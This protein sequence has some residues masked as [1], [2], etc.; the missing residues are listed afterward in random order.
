M[1]QRWERT[2]GESMDALLKKNAVENEHSPKKSGERRED[3]IFVRCRMTN[4]TNASLGHWP[5]LLA[6]HFL[7]V[8][9]TNSETHDN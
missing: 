3:E 9:K 8:F 6:R 1:E 2:L 7:Y 5:R 4:W